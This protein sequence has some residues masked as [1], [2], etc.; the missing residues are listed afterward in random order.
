MTIQKILK[1]A[2]LCL[3]L[4][5]GASAANAGV[6]GGAG[7]SAVAMP[8]SNYFGAGPIANPGY[9]WSST[10][11]STQGG[12]VFGYTGGY[13]FG[14]NGVWSGTP[15]AG[16]N[17][18]S[19]AYSIVDTM[20]FAF[21]APVSAF[22]GEINWLP[23]RLPVTI[24]AYDAS[25]SLI[26]SLT[27]SSGGGNDQPADAF[28]GFIEG[29]ASIKYFTMTDGYIGIRNMQAIGL[30]SGVPEPASWA[31]RILGFFGIGSVLR[32][33]AAVRAIA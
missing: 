17:D 33:R 18:S 20:T 7:G 9:T 12:S 24:A 32:R 1:G 3:V 11:G 25:W 27:L 14:S 22:G 10:N 31:T 5:A 6:W 8:A 21:D 29:S 16:V 15:M 4:A 19:D 28:Y 13:G 2:A 30:S 26:E 23:N